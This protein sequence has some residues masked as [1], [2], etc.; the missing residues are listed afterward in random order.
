MATIQFTQMKEK[1]FT[2]Y[3]A[4]GSL[5]AVAA[6]GLLQL[7]TAG[8]KVNENPMV[9]LFY[10]VIGIISLLGGASIFSRWKGEGRRNSK[11]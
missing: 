11:L 6:F 3:V 2:P 9:V 8:P 5:V 1:S 10:T 7:V 4:L